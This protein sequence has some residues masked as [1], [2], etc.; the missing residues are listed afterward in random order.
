MYRF[1]HYYLAGFINACVMACLI[2]VMSLYAYR[3]LGASSVQLSVLLGGYSL[4]SILYATV[5]SRIVE[6]LGGHKIWL[7]GTSLMASCAVLLLSTTQ[8]YLFAALIMIT[9]FAP[10]HASTSLLM[11]LA[12]RYFPEGQM[13]TVNARLMAT[14]SA[15]WVVCPSV[16]FYMTEHLG[17]NVFFY[18]LGVVLILLALLFGYLPVSGSAIAI[19][20]N[21]CAERHRQAY[22]AKSG[23]PAYPLTKKANGIMDYA[24]LWPPILLFTLLSFGINLYQHLLP[25][26]FVEE[27]LPVSLVGGLFMSAAIVEISLIIRCP[28]LLSRFSYHQLFIVASLCGITF[29]MLLP[30]SQNTSYLFL[31]QILK[32]IMYG[33][34]AGLGVNLLQRLLPSEPTFAAALYQN[35]FAMGMLLAGFATGVAVEFLP[36]QGL[37]SISAFVVMVCLMMLLLFRRAFIVAKAPDN[38]KG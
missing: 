10:F 1:S 32:A 18:A 22:K 27:G 17:F 9:L 14:I 34:M 15:A 36:P 38:I 20:L 31:L 19:D 26:Y 24:Y 4:S 33:I 30:V 6:R 12:F 3:Y 25:V 8:N 23:D 13:T 35:A 2:P 28:S 16:A 29:F 11:G 37:F 21:S 5:I 7:L